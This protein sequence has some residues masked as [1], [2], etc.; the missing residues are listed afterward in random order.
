MTQPLA[1]RNQAWRRGDVQKAVLDRPARGCHALVMLAL[2]LLLLAA[3][4]EPRV[5]NE[6]VIADLR[7][8]QG[9]V[10]ALRLEVVQHLVHLAAAKEESREDL[11]VLRQELR[12]VREAT[13]SAAGS[14]LA[15]PPEGSDLLGV[16]RT[17]VL[18]P[19]IEAE[20]A[21]RRDT[22]VLKLRRIESGGALKV[23]EVAVVPDEDGVDLP[24]DRSGALYL[25]DWSTSEGHTF[26]LLLKDGTSGRTVTTV[27]VKPLQTQG[28]FIFVGVRVD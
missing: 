12:A 21:R 19:R 6:A 16:G 4:Q 7:A 20:S 2:T 11:R 1:G 5:P 17:V 27:P 10:A 23:A 22:V 26:T 25:V 3:P 15:A 9:H 13:A 28:R 14:F 8:L 18:A 24:L